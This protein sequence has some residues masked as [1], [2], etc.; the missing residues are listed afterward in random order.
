M[1]I[2]DFISIDF[3]TANNN[4]DSAC[5]IGIVGVKDMKIIKQDYYL[6]K[7]PSD[8]FRHEHTEIHGICYDDVKNCEQFPY[9]WEKIKDSFLNTDYVIAHN[10]QFDM[11]VLYCLFE[12]YCLN[13]PEFKY[14]DSVNFSSK[15]FDGEGN[16]LEKRACYFN[17][18]ITNH[19]NALN[20]AEICAKII[21]ASIEKSRYRT[22]DSYIKNFTSINKRSFSELKPNKTFIKPHHQHIKISE[23]SAATNEF[24]VS[25]VFYNKNIVVTGEF[26]SM[27]RKTAMQKILDL[28]GII[29]SAVSKKTNYLIVGTQDKK[30]VGEDGLSTKEEKAYDLI[31]SGI[32]IK[33]LKEEEFLKIL[34]L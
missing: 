11:S 22:F 29:K 20:D 28:G 18:D 19:H 24:D 14:I 30:L 34:Q 1:N 6:I 31:Q 32:N 21:I 4:M 17:I 15:V 7:P 33:I 5:S 2:Y 27:D 10:A 26:N 3:E 16:S 23:L 8:H 25:H 12:T 9:I 13:K